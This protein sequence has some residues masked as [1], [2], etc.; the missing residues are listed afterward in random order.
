MSSAYASKLDGVAA[1][2]N[3]FSLPTASGSTLGGVKV[4]TSLN[5]NAGV[6]DVPAAVAGQAGVQKYMQAETFTGNGSQTG[7]TVV[8]NIG[9]Y[10]AVYLSGLRQTPVDDYTV[11]GK[12]ITFLSAPLTGQKIVIDYIAQ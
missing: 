3:N 11:S 7:F 12:V 10:L 5:I 1:N 8:N 6:L 2:A 9:S 4:G